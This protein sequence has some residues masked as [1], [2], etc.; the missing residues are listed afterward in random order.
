MYG[1]K[2]SNMYLIFDLKENTA[3]CSS[4]RREFA[5]F[6]TTPRSLHFVKIPWVGPNNTTICK[7]IFSPETSSFEIVA[8]MCMQRTGSNSLQTYIS[9]IAEEAKDAEQEEVFKID[10]LR[11]EIKQVEFETGEVNKRKAMVETQTEKLVS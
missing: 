6:S 1:A 9:K 2:S 7:I 10:N 11:Y 5:I 8:H 4:H 3:R